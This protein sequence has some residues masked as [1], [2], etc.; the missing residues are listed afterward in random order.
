MKKTLVIMAVCAGCFFTPE[1]YAF[2]PIIYTGN[3]VAKAHDTT[4]QSNYWEGLGL[5]G[6]VGNQY[7]EFKAYEFTVDQNARVQSLSLDATV[8]PWDDGYGSTTPQDIDV[9]FKL[10]KGTRLFGSGNDLP[11]PDRLVFTSDTYTFSSIDGFNSQDYE[12]FEILFGNKIKSNDTYWIWAEN[13]LR[14]S[15]AT[16]YYSTNFIEQIVNPEPATFLLFGSGLMGA[17][18][19]R[20]R[21]RS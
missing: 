14:T 11:A 9:T 1:A 15:P 19:A 12:A 7:I 8:V 3:E 2:L 10:F 21:K 18:A 17:F 6:P 4:M 20:R 13:T 16:F 5:G